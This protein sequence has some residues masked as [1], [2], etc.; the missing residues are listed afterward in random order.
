L[1]GGRL[2][3]W[4]LKTF[5][6]RTE[7]CGLRPH[8][9]VVD[10][11]VVDQ[12]PEEGPGFEVRPPPM[13]SPAGGAGDARLG[14]LADQ[15]LVHVQGP[16]RAV[17]HNSNMMPITVDNPSLGHQRGWVLPAAGRS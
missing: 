14:V 9:A 7:K 6:R 4:I 8:S 10:S 5:A 2:T 13:F 3:R 17:P 11:H 12:A 16:R 1:P 15:D